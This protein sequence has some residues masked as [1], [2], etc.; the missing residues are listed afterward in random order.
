MRI[1]AVPLLL[2]AVAACESDS[3]G[4]NPAPTGDV[5]IVEGASTLGN[6]AFDPSPYT[7]SLASKSTVKWVNNDATTHTIVIPGVTTS[8]N[9][10]PRGTFQA[11]FITTGSYPYHCGIHPSMVGTIEVTP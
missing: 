3:T 1:L 4:N 10:G 7:I 5:S 6:A 11:M 9:L 2:L 8:G